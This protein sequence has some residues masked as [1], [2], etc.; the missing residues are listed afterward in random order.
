MAQQ[1]ILCRA[2]ELELF[3]TGNT[4]CTSSEANVPSVTD[5]NKD[6]TAVTAHDEIYLA[7]AAREVSGYAAQSLFLEVDHCRLLD[8]CTGPLRQGSRRGLVIQTH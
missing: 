3:V 2:D 4:S 6:Q 8:S 1:K 5:L 7:G